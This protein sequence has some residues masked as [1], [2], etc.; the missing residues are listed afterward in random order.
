V[1]SDTPIT[2][3]HY[4]ENQLFSYFL[5]LVIKYIY[6]TIVTELILSD[7]LTI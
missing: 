2:S 6:F 1:P 4:T 7:S 3:L 5:Y